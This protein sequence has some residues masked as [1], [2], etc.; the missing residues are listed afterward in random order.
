[1]TRFARYLVAGALNTAWGYLVIFGLMYLVGLSPE[2]SNV[3]GYLVGLVTSYLLNRAFT[4]RTRGLKGPEFARFLFFFAVAF[5]ANFA[6]L[7]VLLDTFAVDP[8]LAQILAGVVYVLV[9]YALNRS[10]VF[11]R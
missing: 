8:A 1:M 11:R 7:K 9:S 2:A 4:F 5:G 3:G 10:F 6:M